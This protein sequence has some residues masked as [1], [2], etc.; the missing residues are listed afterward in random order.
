MSFTNTYVTQLRSLIEEIFD[1]PIH[2]LW[3]SLLPLIDQNVLDQACAIAP[4]YAKLFEGAG[5]QAISRPAKRLERI[6]VKSK[7][8]AP[9]VPFKVNS[10]L[11]AFRF[12][13]YTISEIPLIMN[14]LKQLFEAEGGSFRIR[15]GITNQEGKFTD[16]VQYAFG[17]IPTLGFVVELQVGHPFASFTFTRDSQIRDLRTRGESTTHLLDMW[18]NGF[19][20]A[21]RDKIL[22]PEKEVDV[23]KFWPGPGPIDDDVHIAMGW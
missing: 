4:A 7:G 10:D 22:H 9:D 19:Y 8:K 14:T 11:V 20:E 5:L 1:Q 23:A 2:S 13:T 18:D 6:L 16:I 3:S 15:N 12:P 21:V 17:Y